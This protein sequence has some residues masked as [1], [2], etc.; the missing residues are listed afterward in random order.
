[1][2]RFLKVPSPAAVIATVA[3]FVSLGGTAWAVKQIG[4]NQIKNN[5]V[6]TKKIKNGAVTG[7]KLANGAVTPAKSSMMWALI[8]A[9]GSV[10]QSSPGV[11]TSPGL[12]GRYYVYFPKSVTGRSIQATLKAVNT[13]QPTSNIAVSQCGY[14]AYDDGDPIQVNCMGANAEN[15]VLVEVFNDNGDAQAKSFYITV[16]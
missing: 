5:A 4:T 13:A 14:E 12:S 8:S 9:D 3:L 15:E 10:L 11:V 6:T 1:M 16:W 7:G 2:S